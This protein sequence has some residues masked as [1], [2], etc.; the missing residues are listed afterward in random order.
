MREGNW[1]MKR[2]TD[3]RR[4]KYGLLASVITLLGIAAIFVLNLLAGKLEDRYGLRLDLTENS[5]YALSEETA[6]ALSALSQ[7]VDIY[8][9]QSESALK[10]GSSYVVQ[11]YELLEGY[12][13]SG[14]VNVEYVDLAS[15]PSFA[16]TFS[17]YSLGSWDIVVACGAKSE[18]LSFS[19]MYEYDSL[20]GSITA[21]LV[22]QKVT[23]AIL[24]VASAEKTKVN[25]ITGYSDA[26][27]EDLI[28]LL[29]SN[30][31]IVSETALL[32]GDLD[33]EAEMAVLWAPSRDM[34]AATLKKLE[35]WMDNDG[36]QGK[37]FFLFLDPN[38][39][40]LT[41]LEAFAAEWGIDVKDGFA[42]EGNKNFY[43]QQPYYPIAQYGDMT[44]AQSMTAQDVTILALCRPLGTLFE[45]RDS[46]ETDVLLTFTG[47]SG[48]LPPEATTLTADMVTG[49]VDGMVLSTRTL[50]GADKTQ[51]RLVVC[52]S[53][54]AFSGE[55][56]TTDVFANGR[57]IA[58]VFSALSGGEAAATGIVAKS[59]VSPVHS[60]SS[61]EMNAAVWIF[62]VILP[63]LILAAGLAVYLKRRHK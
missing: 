53:A 25:V 31:F 6:A 39:S 8:V 24:T 40:G 14:K 56:I 19:E 11:A 58:G 17:A 49:D 4:K 48:V 41:N 55:L 28:S 46:F 54:L 3:K 5:R 9:M 16:S 51:S 61:A 27:P 62:M 35:A 26:L 29:R 12:G 38:H 22:E 20:T 52:G 63:L 34:D 32:T 59:L 13:R 23:G 33:A 44:Y 57:Y 21:S 36:Q 43:Y 60:M 7:E 30:G 18:Q 10:S 37:T 45:S 42:F 47:T 50:Y 15:H 2:V 1:R